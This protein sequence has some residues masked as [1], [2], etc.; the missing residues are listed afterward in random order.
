MSSE[1]LPRNR[2]S[3]TPLPEELIA[4]LRLVAVKAGFHREDIHLFIYAM[5][6]E[7]YPEDVAALA[8]YHETEWMDT[9]D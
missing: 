5:L 6:Q 8:R 3:R 4:V 2:W 7:L 1:D 9:S